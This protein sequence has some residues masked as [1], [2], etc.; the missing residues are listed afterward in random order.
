MVMTKQ[1][2][3]WYEVR[4]KFDGAGESYVK[5]DFI[6]LADDNPRL[7][8]LK[9]ARLIRPEPSDDEYVELTLK[10]RAQKKAGEAPEATT[11]AEATGLPPGP[12][13]SN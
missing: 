12:G 10:G 1:Q 2:L 8:A 7:T 5:G 6:Q 4:R 9:V 13:Q 3:R 11:M